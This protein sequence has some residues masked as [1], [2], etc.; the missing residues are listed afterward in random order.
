MKEILA[1]CGNRCDLC[2]NYYK[3]IEKFGE[4]RIREGWIKYL[5]P[6][7]DNIKCV[8]CLAEGNH[9]R[10]N[11]SIKNCVNEKNLKTCGHCNDLISDSEFCFLLKSDMDIK[12]NALKEHENMPKEDYD[13]FFKAF[14]NEKV[15]IEIY[16]KKK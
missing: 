2:A 1:K 12:E 10:E 8:G 5:S 13:I 16:R 7:P 15:L 4:Q 3:N 6:M 14:E 9:P 11:C